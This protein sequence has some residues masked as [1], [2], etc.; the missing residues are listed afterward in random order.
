MKLKAGDISKITDNLMTKD[1][2]VEKCPNCKSILISQTNDSGRELEI[3]CEDCGETTI[4]TDDEWEIMKQEE[5][6]KQI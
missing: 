2:F 6:E 5:I 3:V 4:I 1:T